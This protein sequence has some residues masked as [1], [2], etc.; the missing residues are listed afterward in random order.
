MHH[1]VAELASDQNFAVYM[2]TLYSGPVTRFFN[3]IPE[4]KPLIEDIDD[5][6]NHVN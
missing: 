6:T 2:C 4:V 5:S 1:L 3:S